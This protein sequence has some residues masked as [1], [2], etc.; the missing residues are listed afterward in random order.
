[1]WNVV[2]LNLCTAYGQVH[3]HS[4]P[5]LGPNTHFGIKYVA[6]LDFNSNFQIQI[7]CHFK[8]LIQ[9]QIR[10]HCFHYSSSVSQCDVTVSGILYNPK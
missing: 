4:A 5:G 2:P 7:H 8:N 1:M 3:V 9:I 10:G 6:F